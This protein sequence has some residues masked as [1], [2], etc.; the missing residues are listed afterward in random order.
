MLRRAIRLA[1]NNYSG[2]AHL[3]ASAQDAHRDLAAIRDQNLFEHSKNTATNSNRL[4]WDVAV[5]FAGVRV[6]LVF[7]RA[8]RGDEFPACARFRADR[9]YS[10]RPQAPSRRSPPWATRN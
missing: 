6:A 2:D 10:P 8:Q 3:A 1:K 7:E 5:L 9:R 4:Q